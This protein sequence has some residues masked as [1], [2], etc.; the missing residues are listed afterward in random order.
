MVERKWSVDVL[1]R[2]AGGASRSRHSDA[3]RASVRK[4]T[5]LFAS[6]RYRSYLLSSIPAKRTFFQDQNLGYG[7]GGLKELELD[8]FDALSL[9]KR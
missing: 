5:Y 7:Y 1:I 6:D 4:L 9:S 8:S 3:D 2:V